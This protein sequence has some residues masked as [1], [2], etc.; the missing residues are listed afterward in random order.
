LKVDINN[1]WNPELYKIN[2]EYNIKMVERTLDDIKFN[3]KK[4]MVCGRG[5]LHHPDFHPR[6]SVPTTNIDSDLYV[7]VDHDPSYVKYVT[8]KGQYVLSLIVNPSVPKKILEIGGKVYWF[9]PD[10]LNYDLPKILD[11]KYPKSN[12]GLAAISVSSYLGINYI[13]LS[14]IKL[15][16]QYKQF[17]EGKKM[18]FERAKKSGTKIF[19][20]DGLLTEKLSYD[21]WCKL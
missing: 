21:D 11:G 16:G 9:S 3:S 18:V 2:S 14:G 7:S 13:L 20:L 4:A 12:S 8:R 15:T 5:E 10:Y 1:Y 6:I 17:L 19:S